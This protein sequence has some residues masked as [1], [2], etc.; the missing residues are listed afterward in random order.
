MACP[1]CADQSY[2]A[3][4]ACPGCEYFAGDD[5]A[6]HERSTDAAGS[7]KC[8]DCGKTM[9][10]TSSNSWSCVCGHYEKF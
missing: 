9:T 7:R 1:K 6:T 3:G 4:K 8:P 2:V 5:T 10:T